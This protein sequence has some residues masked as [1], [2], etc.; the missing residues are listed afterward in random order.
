LGR[1]RSPKM[2]PIVLFPLRIY[3][4]IKTYLYK[5]KT[6]AFGKCKT[7]IFLKGMPKEIHIIFHRPRRG[8]RA[9]FCCRIVAP[10]RRAGNE[11]SRPKSNP[12]TNTPAVNF[13][14]RGYF[15][16][17]C[18]TPATSSWE[19]QQAPS[20]PSVAPAPRVLLPT[21]PEARGRRTSGCR[22]QSPAW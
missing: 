17:S 22:P 10:N 8:F 20:E 7:M 11:Y 18:P 14:R 3:S 16:L 2:M 15:R 4:K 6:P 21:V 13:R 1:L 9:F 12:L 19:R 5:Q